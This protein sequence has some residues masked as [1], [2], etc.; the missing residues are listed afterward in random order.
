MS[1]QYIFTPK[2]P[3]LR[4]CSE[5]LNVALQKYHGDS[6]SRIVDNFSLASNLQQIRQLLNSNTDETCTYFFLAIQTDY[7]ILMSVLRL[8]AKATSKQIKI[9]YLMHEPFL[10]R[11]RT[12]WFKTQ[13]INLHQKIF[14]QLA[15]IILV[16]SSGAFA[17]AERFVPRSKL[18]QINL[19]FTSIHPQWIS[20][21]LKILK[22]SWNVCKTFLMA[23][24]AASVDKNPQGFADFARVVHQ[25]HSEELRF[26]RAG[27][28]RN[29]DVKYDE[30]TIIQFSSYLSETTKSFLF[31]L[32]HFIVIPYL[33][34][35]Q[36][37]VIIEAFRHGK[38]VIAND[39]PAFNHFKNLNFFYTVDFS[40]QNSIL[41]CVDEISSWDVEDYE[42]RCWSALRYFQQN[43]SESYLVQEIEKV[44]EIPC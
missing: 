25:F 42:S 21:S 28:D 29:V 23:G 27:R 20:S 30:R 22:D 16:P 40:N 8:L 41:S 35:T 19:T 7:L 44:F 15:D 33:S 4:H 13:I 12:G 32:S 39:I 1:L 31:G 37:G 17:K 24:T 5:S 43:H 34:S 2:N 26:I 10:E 18:Y 3:I 14:S 11:G 38:I 9:Y 6:Q 36:S